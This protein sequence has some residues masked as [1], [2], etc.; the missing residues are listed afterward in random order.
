MFILVSLTPLAP[1]SG[2]SHLLNYRRKLVKHSGAKFTAHQALL[3]G[4]RAH[5]SS[6]AFQKVKR[7]V[8]GGRQRGGGL[9]QPGC[10]HRHQKGPVLDP[11]Q[12]VLHDLPVL[13]GQE[14]LPFV[15]L[16][17]QSLQHAVA[18]QVQPGVK[19]WRLLRVFHGGGALR[20]TGFS[21]CTDC[22]RA[23]M[24]TCCLRVFFGRSGTS[25]PTATPPAQLYLLFFCAFSSLLASCIHT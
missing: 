13:A 10:V 8:P 6:A 15:L 23:V 12:E 18:N 3:H 16:Q 22:V 11:L 1:A 5:R 7:L 9:Q 25:H 2:A 14:L 21:V 24:E 20:C 4:V 19:C 17:F